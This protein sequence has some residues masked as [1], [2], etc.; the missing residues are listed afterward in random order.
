MAKEYESFAPGKERTTSIGRPLRVA[1]EWVIW[2]IGGYIPGVQP[3]LHA[4]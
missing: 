2:E 4:V 3:L 1:C